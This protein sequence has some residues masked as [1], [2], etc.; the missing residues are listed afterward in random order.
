MVRIA[1]IM[2]LEDD[3]QKIRQAERKLE[4]DVG[5]RTGLAQAAVALTEKLPE[6]TDI[7]SNPEEKFNVDS[8]ILQLANDFKNLK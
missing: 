7:I 2:S 4:F 3:M 8:K 5:R 6:I 1:F